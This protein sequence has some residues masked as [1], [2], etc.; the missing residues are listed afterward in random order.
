MTVGAWA[1]DSWQSN[2]SELLGEKGKIGS[3]EAELYVDASGAGKEFDSERH[4]AFL[5]EEIEV[6][7]SFMNPA[8]DAEGKSG[9]LVDYLMRRP[10]GS[11]IGEVRD[12]NGWT[13]NETAPRDELLS[14]EGHFS[15]TPEEDE[16]EGIYTLE[17]SVKDIPGRRKVLLIAK[18]EFRD[19]GS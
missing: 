17:V 14:A 10:D 16:V 4:R 19:K 11:I 18:V 8:L 3:Y 1:T 9:V 13:V 2:A 5:G 7:V 12:C 15:F 6:H